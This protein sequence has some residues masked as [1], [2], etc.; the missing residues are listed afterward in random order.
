MSPGTHSTETKMKNSHLAILTVIRVALV[1][2]CLVFLHHEWRALLQHHRV[3]IPA[4]WVV[5]LTATSVI[6]VPNPTVRGWSWTAFIALAIGMTLVA[7]TATVWSISAII[8]LSA[9]AFRLRHLHQRQSPPKIVVIGTDVVIPL[10]MKITP[11]AVL[12]NTLSARA[13]AAGE[14]QVGPTE[15]AS[16]TPEVPATPIPAAATPVQP[17]RVKPAAQIIT[18]SGDFSDNMRLPRHDF[19]AVVGMSETKSRL[20]RAAR[21]IVDGTARGRNGVLLFGEAGVGKTFFAEALAG[22]LDLP[23]LSISYGQVASPWVN[24]TP[25]RVRAVF[26]EAR[27][28]ARCVLFIDEIDSFVKPRD[29]HNAHS[30]DRDLTN[31]MLK[32]IVDL[33]G[34]NVVLVAATNFLD[35]LDVAAQREGRF[36]YK[37]EIPAPDIAAR[38]ALL[39]RSITEELGADFALHEPIV[40]LANRWEGFSSARMMAIGGQL[41]EMRRDGIFAGLLTFQIGMKAMRLLNGRKGRLPEDVKDISDIIMPEASRSA[42]RN[43]AYRM[44]ELESLQKLGSALPRGILFSGPPGTGKTH[45]AMALAKSAD[46]AF[47]KTTG[48]DIIADPRS[49]DRLY[50]EACQVRPC[51]LF[52]DEADGILQDRSSSGHGMLTEKILVTL[53]GAGG[54]TPDVLIIAATNHPERFDAAALRSGRLEE[55]IL[56]DVPTKRAMDAYVRKTLASKLA[57]AW[58]V[59]HEA[60]VQ[61]LRLLIGRTISDADALLRKAIAI[62]ALRRVREHT[63][64]LREDDVTQGARA[65]FV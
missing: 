3:H 24:S 1:L 55:K 11:K 48:A 39:T 52:L 63:T 23:L 60:E 44:Q 56:F 64:D 34:S 5:T 2:A 51:V 33:R 43:L 12:D 38:I 20:L 15:R 13:V 36:D 14:R 10:E 19:S 21:E 49:W 16:A 26:E 6:W 22:E 45:G 32:E 37:I 31:T 17:P 8:A 62:A 42:L 35:G 50:R 57:G 29:A 27:R 7:L 53:D 54:R 9:A 28:V 30:M 65:I 40:A 47:L 4:V 61:L 25:Q 18:P 46:W 58:K 59:E 41:R